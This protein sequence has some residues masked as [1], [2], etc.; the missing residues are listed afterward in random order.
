M[1]HDLRQSNPCPHRAPRGAGAG[2]DKQLQTRLSKEQEDEIQQT[3]RGP[4]SSMS[5]ALVAG[6]QLGI[7]PPRRFPAALVTRCRLLPSVTALRGAATS[8]TGRT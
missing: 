7:A 8:R 2:E 1:S 5:N 6:H 3:P 4:D